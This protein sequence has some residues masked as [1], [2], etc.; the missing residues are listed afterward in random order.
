MGCWDNG[1]RE[2]GV[3]WSLMLVGWAKSGN[4][5]IGGCLGSCY[6]DDGGGKKKGHAWE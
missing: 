3:R 2:G 4:E 6:G 1:G 5:G